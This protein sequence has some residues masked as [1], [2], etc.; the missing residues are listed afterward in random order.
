MNK[1]ILAL[2]YS[3]SGQL[4]EIVDSFIQPLKDAGATIEIL[5]VKPVN[6]FPFP[7]TTDQFFEAMPES[8][9]AKP[10]ELEPF[11][12]SETQYDLVIFAYQPWFLSLSI[13]AHSLLVHPA[14]QK[15]IKTS[16]VLTLIGSRNMWL[17]SQE[18]LKKILKENGT[19]LVGNI[20]LSDR[21]SNLISAATI[22]YWM[23][24]GKKERM[25]G[26]F[27]KPGVS[28]EDIQNTATFGR[29]VLPY[30]IAGNYTGM[31]KHLAQQG[32]VE[33]KT[34]L[35]FIEERAPRLFSIWANIINQSKHRKA[36]LLLF[37]YYLLI[38]LFIV[39]PIVLTFYSILFLPFL[40]K[41]ISRKKEYYMAC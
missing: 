6:D 30:L 32:A 23:L 10:I 3:Q 27:P 5:R 39:A 26:L 4:G 29:T 36:W 2:Y 38:A 17:N 11:Q 13:P 35:L 33:V 20:S 12:C 19:K 21:N 22:L 31:Q 8:V 15:I 18:R 1:K 41:S 24:T 7:W 9:L 14:I 28:A 16:P 34:Q 37:K 25:L 40:S